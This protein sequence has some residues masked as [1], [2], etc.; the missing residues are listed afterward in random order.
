MTNYIL[1]S[2][3]DA[4]YKDDTTLDFSQDSNLIEDDYW[5]VNLN[6]T[7]APT[8]DTWTLALRLL[9]ITDEQPSNFGGQEFVTPG[10]YWNSRLRGREVELSAVYRFGG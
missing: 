10:V 8:S 7:L 5:R 1:N 6:F 9:N 4:Y 3:I 2:R